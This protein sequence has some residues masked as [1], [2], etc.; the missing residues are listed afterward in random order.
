[1]PCGKGCDVTGIMNTSGI[2]AAHPKSSYRNFTIDCREKG[3]AD[4]R[5]IHARRE[6]ANNREAVTIEAHTGAP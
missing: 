5:S 2:N 4:D 6:F 1:M 3:L